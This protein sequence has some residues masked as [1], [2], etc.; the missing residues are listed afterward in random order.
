MENTRASHETVALDN[1]CRHK[2]AGLCL[3]TFDAQSLYP[4]RTRKTIMLT[5]TCLGLRTALCAFVAAS[6]AL[7]VPGQAQISTVVF[8]DDFSS[9]T[10]DP[11]KYQPD[12]PFFEGGIGDIHAEAAD[13]VIHFVGTTTQQW[14][15][16]GTLRVVPVFTATE[17]ANV[18]ASIDR[19]SEAGV[20]TAARSALWIL[21]ESRTHYVLFAD[22]RG[23]GGW[24]YNRKIGEDGDVPTGG[25]N[26][27]A[28]FNGG[29]FDDSALH[30]MK[31][32]ADG[33]TVKLFLDNILGEEVKFPF[34]KVVFEF[35]SYARANNDTADTTWDNLRI[36]TTR[37]TT[38]VFSDD[39]SS[40]SID[41]NKYQ[42]DAP[43][44]E[45]GVGDI[46]AEADGS[47]LRFVGTTSQ[48]WWSGG[49]LR[50]V[51]TFSASEDA[52]VALSVDRVSEA[53]VGTAARSALWILDETRTKYVLFADVR[54]EGGWHFNRKIGEDGDVPT[55]GGTDIAAFN[56]GT[57]D[58]SL[59]HRMSV[60]ADGRTVKLLLD[61][62]VGAE[63]KFPFSKVVFELGSYARANN[64]T[65]NTAWDNLV[66]ETANAA[67]S[68]ILADDFSAAAI[69]PTRYVPDAPFF[70]GGTGDI[71]AEAVDGTIKFVGTTTQQW[72][73][74]GTLRVVPVLTASEESTV[75]VSIDRVA[76]AGVGSA[77]RSALWLLD[78]TK[79]RYVLFADVRGE[80]G[81]HFNRK[82][83]ED[84]DVPTGGGTDIG[85]FNG[86]TF[87]DGGLHRM[88][89]VADGKTVKLFLDNQLGAE[90]KFP[91]TK[92]IVEFGS[93]ARANNDT[94]AT[95]W[96][97]LKIETTGSASF[98]PNALSVRPGQSSGDVT[99]RIPDG[100][101][102]QQAITVKVTTSDPTIAIP[103]G[104]TA[105]SLSV[106]F[107]A[108][109]AN[110][111]RFKV[112]GV[113]L[114]GAKF[115]VSG[116]ITAANDLTV[117][118][119]SGP[120]VLLQD[121]FG[122]AAI[123]AA[124]WLTSNRPLETG[125]GTFTVGLNGGA[126][127]ISGT[128][129]V[130][131]WPG[132][133]LQSKNG[134]TATK[135]LNLSVE[136]DRLSIDRTTEAGGDS[137]AARTGVFLTSS[138]HTKYVFFSQNLGENGWTVNVNP[139]SSIGGGSTV[140]AFTD[141]NDTASHHMQLVADGKSV[142]VFLDGRSGGRF[143]F[144]V[145][146]GIY[147]EI[148]AF[149]RAALD[150]VVGQFDNV[151]IQHVL[152]CSAVTPTSISIT[153]A[154]DSASFTLTVPSLLHDAQAAI[155]TVTSR[156]P[157]VAVPA[158]AINGVLTLNF[159]PGAADSKTVQIVPVGRGRTAF[160]LVATPQSCF[161]GPLA[162]EVLAVPQVLL[163]DSFSG[164]AVDESIWRIDNT[165]FVD[166][167]T[168][169]DDS[170]VTV[171]GG[172]VK[173][174]VTN[175]SGAYPGLALFTAGT[176]S[177]T[178]TTPLTFEID[179]VL[180]G[181]V[182]VT[183]TGAIERTGVWVKDSSGNFLFFD[184]DVA[185]D[186]RNWGWRYNR[187][188]GLDDDNPT[189]E[190]INIAAFDP[191]VFNDQGSHHMKVVVNG[192][193]VKLYLDGIFGAEVAF[194]FAGDLSFGF[195]AYVAASKDVVTGYFDN[196]KLSGG[197]GSVIATAVVNG[198]LVI[199]WSG[200]GSLQETASLSAPV[201]WKD[202]TPAP[203]GKTFTVTVPATG[204]KFY[205]LR[206]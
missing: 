103:V 2:K 141:L 129:D 135:E 13:G 98:I 90:V 48:Q 148:G 178:T 151:L 51:P 111:A 115:S 15:S 69:D 188:G 112:R 132:A 113:A 172:K 92:V 126:L 96:D 110:T 55:G 104:G 36:E 23:E 192:E 145:N 194:P 109:G 189:G 88:K 75:T 119:I 165:P 203:V 161:A 42:P 65:A 167:G 125:S 200:P 9:N 81:W 147:V 122:G 63:V 14:W 22:V 26:D 35:G 170:A 47:V 155:V 158:G 120:A 79:T 140:T 204:T 45:G 94:A 187:M 171:E 76:E 196:A 123:D 108:G 185:H 186:G 146:A 68:L 116:G 144:T 205:S 136:L 53:G 72:W 37:K 179:R 169:T 40:T 12:A 173:I 100:L 57:F 1:F 32:V 184:E 162:V 19:V 28:L 190:G 102:A 59:L 106:T 60:V 127:E 202:V 139:G 44:F 150:R 160:D 52:P 154:D 101:N 199:S 168:A 5:L 84:G 174:N 78:E 93:Y 58:D 181:Y 180:L 133:S 74:G 134:F 201:V 193:T 54:G 138:D 31:I 49:T 50:V 24:H 56:G 71:H 114:G 117:A 137:T 143:E 175:L 163:T 89:M 183:G 29:T 25:G 157:K 67:T 198:K 86:G 4:P 107:P 153:E 34:S 99:L 21:D 18:V 124:K 159:G 197:E 70:E 206:P 91:F 182:L 83:G 43:F 95:T 85:S 82:I 87:D 73:S 46:H 30:R 128:T 166:G 61:G 156:D 131:Y 97:N 27:V 38:V 177:A 20:G 62:E 195:G 16:G 11:N 77:S 33:K 105:G 10:L 80:G 191:A 121:D 6:L 41:P 142:E 66:I 130:Q 7:A 8:Q 17:D 152:P 3:D 39:F 149:A 176:Y 64:D 118:V 164:E